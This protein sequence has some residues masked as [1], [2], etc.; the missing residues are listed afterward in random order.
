MILHVAFKLYIFLYIYLCLFIIDGSEISVNLDRFD[1]G[2]ISNNHENSP[3]IVFPNDVVV[4]F[5]MMKAESN[6]N[7]MELCNETKEHFGSSL[8]VN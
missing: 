8:E 3:S 2:T 4:P 6:T 5:K 7:G 1:P